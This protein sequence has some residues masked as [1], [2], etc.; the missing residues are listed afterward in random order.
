MKRILKRL[1][2]PLTVVLLAGCTAM[3]LSVPSMLGYT[4]LQTA[5]YDNDQAKVRQLLD[6]GADVRGKGK[7]GDDA[8]SLASSCGRT[9]I[10]K[11][12][13]DAGAD[14]NRDLNGYSAIKCAAYNNHAETVGLLLDRGATDGGGALLM[15]SQRGHAET[16]RLL[17]NRGIDVNTKNTQGKTALELAR[18]NGKT[19]VV[20]LIQSTMN[21]QMAAQLN[22][23][24]L[25]Q[26]LAQNN[27]AN[28]ALVG[29]LAD[30]LI[31][32]KNRELPGL[33]A[34]STL[35]RRIAL[36][37]TVEKRL[38]EAQTTI[39][40]LTGKAEDAVRKGQDSSGYRRHIGKLQAYMAVLTEMKNMLMQ[41]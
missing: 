3:P 28:E 15:A 32:A 33:I 31:E 5:V 11:L 4:P 25:P 8:L 39:V 20:D 9:E 27:F 30:K 22:N 14:I 36:V 6:N 24:T 40:E 7:Y 26:L 12:L 38:A 17:L 2:I 34:A 13:L 1:P 23:A 21:Q 35:D 10:V 41:S 29:M 19:A 16:V 37:T 18:E